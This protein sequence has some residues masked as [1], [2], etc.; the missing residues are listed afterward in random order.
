MFSRMRVGQLALALAIVVLPMRAMAGEVTVAVAANFLGTL[1]SLQ[2]DFEASGDHKLKIVSGATGKLAAQITEGAPFDVFLAADNK[3]PKKVAE[4][5]RA[6]ADTEFTYAIGTLALYSADPAR[7]KD[8]GA[9]VLKAGDFRKLAIANPK[10]A[11]YGVAAESALKALG[12]AE[13]VKDKIVMGENIGQT[14]TMIDTGNAEVGFVALSQ[15]LGSESGKKGSHWKVPADL[16]DPIRQDAIL[17]DHGKDN[18]DAKAF[19][20][21]LKSAEAKAKIDAAGYATE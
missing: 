4:G 8:D 6:V 12:V 9:A 19:L 7:I 20:D 18:A 3:A 21:F 5:G 17:L 14:F 15:V 11:P 16:H 2:K 1:E 10:V 13:A